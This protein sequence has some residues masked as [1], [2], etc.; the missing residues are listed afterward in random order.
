M[1]RRNKKRTSF[2]RAKP[3]YKTRRVKKA[4]KANYVVKDRRVP[5]TVAYKTEKKQSV[6]KDAYKSYFVEVHRPSCKKERERV[7]RAYFSYKANMPR[8][9]RKRRQHKNRLT[10]RPCRS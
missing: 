2:R 10:K 6:L 8:G 7:R 4:R 1:T 5:K 3:G 9:G